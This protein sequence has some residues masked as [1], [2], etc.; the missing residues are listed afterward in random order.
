MREAVGL[1][2]LCRR[3][4]C[5]ESKCESPLSTVSGSQ[6]ESETQLFQL[7]LVVVCGH[8]GKEQMR[9]RS[10]LFLANCFW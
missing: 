8:T 4:T 7:F 3:L 1:V 5:K 9:A 2:N 10:Q 6:L